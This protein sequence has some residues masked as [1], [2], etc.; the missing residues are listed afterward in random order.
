MLKNKIFYTVAVLALCTAAL[1]SCTGGNQ[2]TGESESHTSGGIMSDIQEGVSGVESDIKE[3]VNGIE[4]DIRDGGIG[5][6]EDATHGTD[7]QRAR[8]E[9]SDKHRESVPFG[10]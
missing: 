4:S 2:T 9:E 7:G 5:D 10:K 8:N 6:K 1:A 3:G